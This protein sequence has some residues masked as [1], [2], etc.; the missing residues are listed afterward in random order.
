MKVY[1]V[2]AS[3]IEYLESIEIEAETES[4]A[5]DKYT[6]LWEAGMLLPINSLFAGDS[7]FTIDEVKEVVLEK[8]TKIND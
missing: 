3:Y 5:M 7:N 2:N 4:E 1:K 6:E 8:I